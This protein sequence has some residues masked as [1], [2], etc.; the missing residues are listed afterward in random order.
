MAGSP[1]APFRTSVAT[2][3]AGATAGIAP[4]TAQSVAEPWQIWHPEAVTPAAERIFDLHLLLF[5]LMFAVCA[6]VMILLLYVI[7]RF[8]ASRHPVPSRR[9]HNTVLEVTWTVVPLLVLVTIAVPS[10]RALYYIDRGADADMTVKAVGHQWYWEY[11]YPDHGNL[12]F[13]SIP[14]PDEE[15]KPGQPRL[16]QVDNPLVLP[17]GAKVR[18]LTTSQDVIHAWAV[19]AFGIKMDSVPGHLAERWIQA[20]REGTYFGQCSE[21]CGTN[22][23]FMPVMV[24]VVSRSE[25]ESWLK[26]ARAKFAAGSAPQPVSHAAANR[27]ER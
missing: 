8:R 14:I 15:L 21:L 3:L 16:L 20:T 7:V 5:V 23:H 9:T 17:V 26:D 11:Q 24:R 10:F 1:V 19:P 6:L 25:F 18:I 12:T 4:A 2:V 22:H 27:K 13:S